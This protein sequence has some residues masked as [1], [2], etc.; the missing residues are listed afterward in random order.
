MKKKKKKKKKQ[1]SPTQTPINV[2]R[3]LASPRFDGVCS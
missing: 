1:L 3:V 2:Q